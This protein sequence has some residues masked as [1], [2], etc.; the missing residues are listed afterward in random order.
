MWQLK[1][2][3]LHHVTLYVSD[4]LML[5]DVRSHNHTHLN[6]LNEYFLNAVYSYSGLIC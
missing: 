6:D 1:T 5:Q 4:I 3:S 2:H